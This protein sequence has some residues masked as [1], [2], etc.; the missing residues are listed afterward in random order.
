MFQL[1]Q[2]EFY[3][4]WKI[5]NFNTSVSSFF[6]FSTLTLLVGRQKGHPACKKT[7]CWFLGGDDFARA[8]HDL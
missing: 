4:S 8:L 7:R 6:S 5:P 2:N 1:K 3:L